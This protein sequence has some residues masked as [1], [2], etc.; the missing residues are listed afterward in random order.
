MGVLELIQQ[1]AFIG[2]EFLT[3][4]WYR[5]ENDPAFDLEKNRRCDVEIMGPIV[6]DAHYG[7]ARSTAL[8]GDSPAT[9]P[10]A[11]TALMEGKKLKR[12]RIKFSSDGVDFVAA[13]DGDNFNMSGLNLPRTGQLPFEEVLRL[14]MDYVSEF[15]GLF[16]GMFQ[17]FME[18]RMDEKAWG[19]EL[20]KIQAWVGGK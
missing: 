8:R 18:L 2:K 19:A 1:K 14:R 6:L 16:E 7:D 12:A 11:A 13:I 5:A 10:E 15:E 17:Q 20:E 9:A 4:L 3:W